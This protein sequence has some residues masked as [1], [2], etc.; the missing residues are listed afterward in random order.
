MHGHNL[1]LLEGEDKLIPAKVLLHL[2]VPIPAP[3][4]PPSIIILLL[5]TLIHV[6]THN[7]HRVLSRIGI[8]ILGGGGEK[9]CTQS[10]QNN[11]I[12]KHM[13]RGGSKILSRGEHKGARCDF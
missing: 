1:E 13:T 10:T 9:S 6:D 7:A 8:F 5:T 11:I 4:V 2:P 3:P 12:H